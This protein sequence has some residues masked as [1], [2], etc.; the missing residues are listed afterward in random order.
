MVW[1]PGWPGCHDGDQKAKLNTHSSAIDVGEG[2]TQK[3]PT[4]P[5][6][7]CHWELSQNVFFP[8]DNSFWETPLEIK[9]GRWKTAFRAP[10]PDT[11]CV[12]VWAR[13]FSWDRPQKPLSSRGWG[14]QPVCSH[15]VLSD[16]CTHWVGVSRVG[17]FDPDTSG[18]RGGLLS[19]TPPRNAHNRVEK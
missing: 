19:I 3:T 5:P 14:G 15:R 4:P 7:G 13:V 12:C 18:I 17:G 11:E 6:T 1:L 10:N 16:R 8:N 2:P 9:G